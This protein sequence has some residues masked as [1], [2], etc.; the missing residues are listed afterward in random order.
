MF[1]LAAL[2]LAGCGA[3][4]TVVRNLEVGR[5]NDAGLIGPF[6]GGLQRVEIA[7]APPDG[8]TPAQVAAGMALPA[9]FPATRFEAVAPGGG[10]RRVVLEFGVVG[11]P[12]AACVAPRQAAAPT[13]VAT[14]TLCDGARAL[15]AATLSTPRV[16]GPSAPEFTRAVQALMAEV[17]RAQRIKGTGDD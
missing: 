16:A 10:G 11:G 8:A 3:G 5:I 14:A 2:A 12:P 7:G 9:G 13:L 1:A 6:T 15:R 17:L 4:G